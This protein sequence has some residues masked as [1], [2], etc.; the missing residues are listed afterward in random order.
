M[1]F[2]ELEKIVSKSKSP[3][4]LFGDKLDEK[5][6][7]FRI[8]CHP[9][10]FAGDPAKQARAE[11]LFKA[12]EL[13]AVT[14]R[15]PSLE[16][17]SRKNTYKVGNLLAKGDLADLYYADNVILKIGRVSLAEAFLK[18]EVE[19][20]KKLFK[21][22]E[23]STYIKYLPRLIESFNVFNKFD[24]LINVFEY[25]S[26]Y[27]PLSNFT[28]N[29]KKEPRHLVWLFKRILTI[30]SFTEANNI[31]HGAVLPSHILVNPKNHGIQLIGWGQSVEKGS[32]IK[33]I[34]KDWKANYPSEVLD[35]KP[36]DFSTDIYMVGYLIKQLMTSKTPSS[37]VRFVDSLLLSPG[38]RPNSALGL[39][40]DLSH[41]ARDLYG[42]PK[43]VT[44]QAD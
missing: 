37:F 15:S 35:K 17:K 16:I 6:H 18:Q 8:A 36:A 19:V 33:I 29:I 32:P 1:T 2:E 3:A 41:F 25:D 38:M 21:V 23:D 30:L 12:I 7:E 10:R 43:F 14:A 27:A 39:Y 22:G 34:S 13:F 24:R 26:E 11:E 20:L 9:D 4:D 31:V 42:S 40:D 5:L 28:E 44:L